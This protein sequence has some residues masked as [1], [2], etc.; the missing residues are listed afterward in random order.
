MTRSFIELPLFR[1]KWEDLGLTDKDLRRLQ[2]SLL[3]DPKI[4]AVMRGTGGVR[5]MRFAFEHRGKSGSIRVIYVDFEVYEK[6]Y[7]LTAYTKNEKDNL[8]EKEQNELRRLIEILENQLA[9][10][11]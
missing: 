6:I 11:K 1:S 5:K 2:E 7:L 9:D 3:A 10:N 4:G 8:T